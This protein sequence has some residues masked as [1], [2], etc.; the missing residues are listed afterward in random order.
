MLSMW[1]SLSSWTRWTRK[2]PA[3]CRSSQSTA[4][5]WLAVEMFTTTSRPSRRHWAASNII[6]GPTSYGYGGG[7]PIGSVGPPIAWRRT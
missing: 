6:S 2:R 1:L 4:S 7:S 3:T 5:A